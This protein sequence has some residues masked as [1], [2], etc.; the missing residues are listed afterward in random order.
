MNCVKIASPNYLFAE[1][2]VFFHPPKFALSFVPSSSLFSKSGPM[3]MDS[4]HCFWTAKCMQ[5]TTPSEAGLSGDPKQTAF[6]WNR[7]GY[8][9]T[10]WCNGKIIIFNGDILNIQEKWFQFAAEGST[11]C[12]D[13][14]ALAD[15][16]DPKSAWHRKCTT[17]ISGVYALSPIW[18]CCD[19]VVWRC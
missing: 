19:F 15:S 4:L 11:T 9:L 2:M 13:S 16:N 12:V 5:D 10:Q 3:A 14:S 6:R 1:S 7:L 18:G 17:G 8:P